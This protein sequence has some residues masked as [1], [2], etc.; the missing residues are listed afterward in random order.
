MIDDILK[1]SQIDFLQK[2]IKKLP[3]TGFIPPLIEW[4][5]EK[6][7]LPSGTTEFPGQ[8]SRK[9]A[10]HLV[11]PLEMLHPDNPVTHVAMKKSVQSLNTT[12]IAE[13]A[14]GSWIDY[15]LGSV[16]FQLLLREL[17]T[18]GVHRPLM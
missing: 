15:Q 1:E 4:A 5:E 9:T 17:R 10:P 2:R 18:L 12:T 13:N 3:E 16:L 14:I 8:F 11:E 6:R 7:F